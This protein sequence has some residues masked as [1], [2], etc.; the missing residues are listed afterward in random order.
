MPFSL[1]LKLVILLFTGFSIMF[2]IDTE[3]PRFKST[4]RAI[5]YA[6]LSLLV[7]VGTIILVFAG[8]GY[9][10][11]RGTGQVIQNGLLLINTLPENALVTINGQPESDQTPGRFALPA[12]EY[13]LALSLDG[14]RDWNK[15]ITVTPSGVEW[16]YYPLLVPIEL[17]TARVG[18]WRNLEFIAP[19]PNGRSL[20]V[21]QATKQLSFSLVEVDNAAVT[22]ELTINPPATMLDL[23]EGDSIGTFNFIEWSENGRHALVGYEQ[24]ELAQILWLDTENPSNSLNLNQVFDLN[25]SEPVF[26][27]GDAQRLYV[28]VEGDLRRLDLDERTISA[29]LARGVASY[30]ATRD[31]FVTY[32]ASVDGVTQ[33][34]LIEGNDARLLRNNLDGA[35]SRYDFT[36][37]EFDREFYLALLDT[38]NNQLVIATN[39][40]Q[41]DSS[42]AD[43]VLDSPGARFVSFSV[44]GQFALAQGGGSF[45]SYDLDRARTHRY[46]TPFVQPAEAEMVWMDGYRL[47]GFD[48]KGQMHIFEFDG[49]NAEKMLAVNPAF[50]VFFTPDFDA[51]YSVSPLDQS[52]NSF[53]MHTSLINE[54]VN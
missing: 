49:G 39:P 17:T 28:L 3:S 25:L 8:Q 20:L 44:N 41:P 46:N 21:R 10:F 48:R 47:V 5:Q 9:D 11:N 37:A 26:I 4:L 53:L 13:D 31:R 42:V 6:V 30:K 34:G 29:P 24:G 12:G 15:Q 45:V 23:S 43:V 1:P 52:R 2:S 16:V 18:V 38:L 32:L 36:V 14:Y 22:N 33:I 54:K 7:V 35:A 40:H 51:L 19:T 27:D 50:D